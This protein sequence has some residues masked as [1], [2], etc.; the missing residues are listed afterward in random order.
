[1]PGVTEGQTCEGNVACE[2]GPCLSTGGNPAICYLDCEG[3]AGA[4]NNAQTCETYQLTGGGSVSVC[5]PPGVPPNPPDAGVIFPDAST[6]PDG[7]N[8][9]PDGGNVGN[10]GGLNK[11]DSGQNPQNC[12]C[13]TTFSCDPN[14]SHCDPEC[15]PCDCD[16][17]TACDPGCG[18][19]DPECIDGI[20]RGTGCIGC[21]S[22]HSP[23]DPL[24]S[25][26]VAA[27]LVGLFL[28]RKRR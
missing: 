14:C 15:G 2:V 28:S 24:F 27:L 12:D 3:N 11:P 7:G 5:E 26:L 18:S 20:D 4:C 9:D 16:I 23:V 13:D 6:D 19:C 25:S 10:D 8:I 17:T 22:T 21:T 1:L